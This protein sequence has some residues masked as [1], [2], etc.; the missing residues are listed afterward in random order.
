MDKMIPEAEEQLKKFTHNET[1]FDESTYKNHYDLA[2]K[3]I[4][5]KATKRSTIPQARDLDRYLTSG[6]MI[7]G[8]RPS[9]ER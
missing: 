8:K 3:Q 5:P 2:V 4:M 9:T 6:L 1:P 7:L